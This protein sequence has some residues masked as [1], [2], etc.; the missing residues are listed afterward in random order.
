[1]LIAFKDATPGVTTPAASVPSQPVAAL[2]AM[3]V[4]RAA[5]LPDAQKRTVARPA[6]YRPPRINSATAARAKQIASPGPDLVRIA[7][8]RHETEFFVVTQTAAYDGEG[9]TMWRVCVWRVNLA[10]RTEDAIERGFVAN[11][12]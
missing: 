2:P 11:S 3:A 5:S 1:M 4:V 6:V 9:L 8:K 12:L 10:A 7:A